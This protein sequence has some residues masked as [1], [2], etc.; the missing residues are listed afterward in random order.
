MA[1]VELR[2]KALLQAE[3]ATEAARQIHEVSDAVQE[4]LAVAE[5]QE[6]ATRERLGGSFEAIAQ[7][8]ARSSQTLQQ[9]RVDL[10]R[11]ALEA[12]DFSAA[13]RYLAQA[14]LEGEPLHLINRVGTKLLHARRAQSPDPEEDLEE[15]RYTDPRNARRAGRF[16]TLL[17][18]TRLNIG[19]GRIQQASQNLREAELVLE[20][21]RR[22][23]KNTEAIEK[24]TKAL[25]EH[26][27]ALKN[28]QQTTE[29]PG[30]GPGGIDLEGM[31][32]ML[33]KRGIG[34]GLG[35]LGG[36]G[37]FI[38]SVARFLGPVG[39]ALAAGAAVAGLGNLAFSAASNLARAGRDEGEFFLNLNRRMGQ[40][41]LIYEEFLNAGR[42]PG[43]A[44][45]STRRELAQLGYNAR[46]AGEFAAEYGIPQAG[47]GL[48]RDT[49]AGLRLARYTGMDPGQVASL[50][51][52]GVRADVTGP[53]SAEYLS[54][55][56]FSAVREGTKEGVS[57]SETFAAMNRYLEGLT[58]RGITGDLTSTAAM[59]LYLDR[60]NETGN[61]GLMGEA[62]ARQL[63]GL[64]GGLANTSAGGMDLVVM[65]AL[66]QNLGNLS[67]GAVGLE[68]GAARQYE[69]L[70][71][72]DPYAAARMLQERVQTGNP[73][74]LRTLGRSLQA[75]LGNNP[76]LEAEIF[77]Q[78][79][80]SREAIA[81][82]EG[83]YGSVGAF[84]S[85]AS[86]AEIK[87]FT[88]QAPT[89]SAVGGE[90]KR[91]GLAAELQR[92]QEGE[93]ERIK[94]LTASLQDLD[95]VVRQHL[96][97][98]FDRLY[99]M[100]RAA[101]DGL[102]MLSPE[103]VRAILRGDIA[104]T[105]AMPSGQIKTPEE[106]RVA[107]AVAAPGATKAL[108]PDTGPG[109]V[110]GDA[111]LQN[112]QMPTGGTLM[113][114]M[115]ATQI[116]MD[117]GGTYPESTLAEIRRQHGGKLPSWATLPHNGV[118]LRIGKPGVSDPV[119]SP[120]PRGTK[121]KRIIRDQP[122]QKHGTIDLELET[123]EGQAFILRHLTPE[124]RSGLK[125]GLLLPQGYLL[126]YEGNEGD[127]VHVHLEAVGVDSRNTQEF[128]KA[129][130][131]LGFKAVGNRGYA[132]GGYTGDG[133][134][135]DP[136]GIV[137]R[138]EFVVNEAA[139]RM[140]RPQLEAIN[141]GMSGG[142]V[143]EKQVVIPIFV[144]GDDNPQARALAD[145]LND[146]LRKYK[147]E[148]LSPFNEGQRRGR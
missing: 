102:G 127:G 91:L 4:Y 42:V 74:I 122:W 115:G 9:M 50:L 132:S 26:R 98:G 114:A 119:Y 56:L 37:G 34:T 123:P 97:E 141:A 106:A 51:Q 23:E 13:G 86:D 58:S 107:T 47:A 89:D 54:R 66:M 68:G 145:L 128:S 69:R 147:A 79:G 148:H 53:G 49:L 30:A 60:L 120:F 135:L 39:T 43:L 104:E 111:P 144:P 65:D 48:F 12:G 11:Q 133:H 94:A 99:N 62:G 3:G 139:T 109:T 73:A 85:S 63:S 57:A 84:L 64:L 138:G 33:T 40:D 90:A 61:R 10:A 113:E 71:K 31:I 93:L 8:A 142:T 116:T 146:A 67:A 96:L 1:D 24:N 80:L 45:A 5:A 92:Y 18:R 76:T 82:I 16:E 72:S 59:A 140:F 100:S 35:G 129:I 32:D 88:A 118:D 46:E 124:A 75:A 17:E 125:E 134:P 95:L 70:R 136:A 121:V 131:K 28:A 110:M 103:R 20:E 7:E 22:Q 15:P 143:A 36:L 101:A 77:S 44:Y 87:R 52:A 126:G 130:Q 2:I 78:M 19:T 83:R 108:S 41:G 14:R 117:P 137:H 21:M 6:A 29:T 112:Y 81:E 55:I 25:E 38:S 27:Q 105:P